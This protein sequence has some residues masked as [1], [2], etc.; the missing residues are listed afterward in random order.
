MTFLGITVAGNGFILGTMLGSLVIGVWAL[1]A[2]ICDRD[3][4]DGD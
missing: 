4:F 3:M 1:F 2:P